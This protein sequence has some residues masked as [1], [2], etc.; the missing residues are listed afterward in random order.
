[1]ADAVGSTGRG[2]GR[3]RRVRVQTQIAH[4]KHMIEPSKWTSGDMAS[5]RSASEVFMAFHPW[6][7][8]RGN[9]QFPAEQT[10]HGTGSP[11]G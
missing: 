6:L 5:K 9:E 11:L 8:P 4:G 10:S 2:G 7:E 3:R 1:M